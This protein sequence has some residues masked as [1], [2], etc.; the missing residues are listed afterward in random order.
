[1]PKLNLETK[2][3]A[4]ELVKAYLEENASEILADKINNGVRI[5]KDGKTL[6]SKKTLDGFMAF[7]TDEARKQAEK[8]ARSACVEDAVVFGWAVHFFEEV[9]SK[10]HSSTRTVRNTSRRSPFQNQSLPF[11]QH[12]HPHPNP[13]RRCRSS[14]CSTLRLKNIQSLPFHRSRK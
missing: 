8:S 6:I 12:L 4:Q 9:P 2:N 5:Q 14:I 1:M 13:S 7:A 11:L 10:A 3:K